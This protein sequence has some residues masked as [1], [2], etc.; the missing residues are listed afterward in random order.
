MKTISIIGAGVMGSAITTALVK[1]KIFSPKNIIV[2]DLDSKKLARLKKLGVQ[3]MK[4]T[5]MAAVSA[6]YVLLAVKPQQVAAVCEDWET[7]E[8]IISI[9]AGTKIEKLK[10]LTGSKK[11]VRIMP[12]T[13][14]QIGAGMSGWIATKNI[15]A[16]DK[17]LMKK[18]AASLGKEVELKNEK[19]IDSVTAVSGSGPAYFFAFVE[20]LTEAAKK[21][22][23]GKNAELFASQTFFGAAKLAEDSK[24]DFKTLRENV[25]SK[26]GTTEA[27]LNALKKGKL[28][29]LV[30]QAAKAARQRSEELGKCTL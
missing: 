22:G 8:I 5:A 12:N 9:L 1:Q 28:G 25:T 18:I 21:L 20:A 16:T 2:V 19:L 26:K 13:P 17:K 10:K 23:L 24:L 29:K 11:I 27:A 6:D 14:S 4:D 15:P 3:T 7:D 30:E